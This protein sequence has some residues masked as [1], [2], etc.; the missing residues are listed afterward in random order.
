MTA[1]TVHD[2]PWRRRLLEDVRERLFTP[3][4]GRPV[5]ERYGAEVELLALDAETGRP[6]TIFG[7]RV[8][9]DDVA[10]SDDV[11]YSAAGRAGSLAFLRAYGSP[12]GWRVEDGPHGAPAIRL[13]DGGR[14]SYEPGGQI[15]YA[16][17]P[18]ST[19][20]ELTAELD[21]VVTP[22]VTAAA[23]AGIRLVGRGIDP[24]NPLERA[25]PVLPGERYTAMRRYLSRI[26]DAGPRMMLQT[27]A[28]QVN[29]ELADAGG[30]DA[31]LRWRVLHAAAPYL[32]AT[33]ASS[34]VY[35]GADSGYA[36]FRARQWRLLDRRRTGVLGREADLAAEYTDF[37]LEAGWIFAPEDREPDPFGDWVVRGEVTLEDWRKHLTTLFPE[38]RP[39][40]FL[41]VRCID[42][43]PPEWC[44]VPVSLVAGLVADS[45]SLEEAA[46][47][48]GAP[49]S[50]LLQD[51][52]RL[53]VR[54]PRLGPGAAALFEIALRA[55]ERTGVLGGRPLEVA[56]A[57]LEGYTARGRAPGDEGVGAAA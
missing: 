57:F 15:E 43:L 50:M 29:V 16:T 7:D 55:G 41:E 48:V 45:R 22:L 30:R 3:A 38:I 52:A 12:L 24:V 1:C 33:F 10:G 40:G 39:R 36:S 20:A 18:R 49:D 28:I 42:A 35:A 27:A 26:G 51:A 19:V 46:E 8:G 25:R 5:G 47:V 37:A 14:I 6:L 2:S 17:L 44:S 32:T 9:G 21:R 4:S 53:G 54:D 31:D 23:D 13:P 34:R 11:A 56:R